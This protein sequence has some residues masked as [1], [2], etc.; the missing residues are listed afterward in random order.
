MKND[1]FSKRLDGRYASSI[2]WEAVPQQKCSLPCRW[3]FQQEGCTWSR[4]EASS[5]IRIRRTRRRSLRSLPL[6]EPLLHRRHLRMWET[7]QCLNTPH[8]VLLDCCGLVNGSCVKYSVHPF[9]ICW[10][11]MS[12]FHQSTL[13]EEKKWHIHT[14]L[15]LTHRLSPE[16]PL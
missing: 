8:E 2:L 3:W 4:K 15:T 5:R 10:P 9:S 14:T 12:T 6:R 13:Q 1:L 16:K 7:G 11:P